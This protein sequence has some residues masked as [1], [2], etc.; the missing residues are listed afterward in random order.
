M[1]IRNLKPTSPGSRFASRNDFS[2]ITKILY[3]KSYYLKNKSRVSPKINY[4]EVIKKRLKECVYK[5]YLLDIQ[6]YYKSHIRYS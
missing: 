6:N 2:E 1:G 3:G 5:N 4:S